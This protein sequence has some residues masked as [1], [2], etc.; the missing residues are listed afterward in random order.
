LRLTK[1]NQ[2]E[3]Q[4]RKNPDGQSGNGKPNHGMAAF[5][6]P[7]ME[8]RFSSEDRT[9]DTLLSYAGRAWGLDADSILYA[10]LCYPGIQ[11]YGLHP[12]WPE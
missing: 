5:H 8:L 4:N 3:R 7:W 6:F 12:P 9:S 11:Q 1:R 2:D 10:G